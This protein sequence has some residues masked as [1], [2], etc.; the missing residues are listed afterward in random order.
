MSNLNIQDLKNDGDFIEIPHDEHEITIW[1]RG[2]KFFLE[3]NS[4]F[5]KMAKTVKPILNKLEQL[6][7]GN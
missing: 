7:G 5:I 3:F 2:G 1:L 6:V 4:K